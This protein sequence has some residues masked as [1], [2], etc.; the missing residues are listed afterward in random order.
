MVSVELLDNVNGNFIKQMHNKFNKMFKFK[1]SYKYFYDIFK[2]AKSCAVIKNNDEIVGLFIYTVCC[3]NNLSVLHIHLLVIDKHKVPDI[4]I[5]KLI[6]EHILSQG[7]WIDIVT[8]Y[9]HRSKQL[10][11]F[12]L[13]IGG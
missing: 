10:K 9:K 2:N 11:Y 5:K 8:Y 4:N 1:V 6:Y 7:Y 3:V 12:K 13:K